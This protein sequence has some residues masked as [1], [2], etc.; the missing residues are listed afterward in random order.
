MSTFYEDVANIQGTIDKVINKE[1]ERINQ[2]SAGIT[3]AYQT[4]QR[5]IMLNESYAA[6]MRGWSYLIA[7]IA[8]A[9]VITIILTN[10]RDI[11]PS[12]I[13]DI[14]IVLVI[15]ITLIWGYFIYTDIQ[16]RDRNDYTLLSMES[17]NLIN[18]NNIPAPDAATNPN[19][20]SVTSN[21]IA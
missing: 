20:H 4:Q 10:M 14:L 15:S 11:I 21:N 3:A 2:K 17:N 6:R 16:K 19:K 7:V 18:P 8:M 12:T 9:L 5:N 13:V 1:Q